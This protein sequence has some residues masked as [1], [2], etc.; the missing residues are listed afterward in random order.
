[1][2]YNTCGPLIPPTCDSPEGKDG[3]EGGCFCPD[4]SFLT[5]DGKCVT[6]CP[7]LRC[8]SFDVHRHLLSWSMIYGAR[9]ANSYIS[10]VIMFVV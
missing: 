9:F 1:M 3:C 4:G 6:E 5:M 2:E 8:V 10:I 7:G